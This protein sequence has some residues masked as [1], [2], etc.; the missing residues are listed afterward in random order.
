MIPLAT[1][2]TEI[3]RY[4]LLSVD[5]EQRLARDERQGRP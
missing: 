2:L 1:Y 3:N 5:E 4:P